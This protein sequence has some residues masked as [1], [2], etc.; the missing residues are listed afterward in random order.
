MSVDT[1]TPVYRGAGPGSGAPWQHVRGPAQSQLPDLPGRRL[2]LQHRHLDAA[3]GPGLAGAGAVRRIGPGHRRHHRAAVPAHAA[4]HPVRRPDRRPVRQ[5]SHPQDHPVVAGAV[6]PGARAAGRDRRRHDRARLP[7]GA[8]LRP[9]RGLRQPGAADLRGRD[10]RPRAPAQRHRSEL[11]ELSRGAHHRSGGGRAGDRGLRL[12]LG[13]PHQL[14]DLCRVH[15]GAGAARRPPVDHRPAG[16][17][18]PSARS[19][20]AWR[21]SGGTTGSCW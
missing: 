19:A 11:R 18:G 4:A 14:S 3:G 5:A 15:R 9:R 10:R 7:A 6:R 20:K 12:R 1:K 17:L 8:A 21:M 2:R 13:D 16:R